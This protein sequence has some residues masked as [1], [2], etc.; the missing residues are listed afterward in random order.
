MRPLSENNIE[1]EL[2]YAYLHAIAAKAGVGCEVA[3]RHD[4][5]T[6][7]D[8]KLTGWGPFPGGGYR[9]EIDIKVQLKATVQIPNE[10]NG[11]LSY[12]L[13][14]VQ[15]YDDLRSDAVSTP[16]ILVVLFLPPVAEEW[17]SL[18]DDGLLLRKC[19]YW[20]SL[21]GAAHT[22]NKSGQT[23]YL[24]KTQIFGQDELVKLM[25]CLSKNIIPLYQC[26][27]EE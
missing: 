21:R 1:S 19:A 24:P 8:A 15:Q 23:I 11:K 18:T 7:V 14:G 9:T 3:G 16:R 13:K 27:G 5:N 20:V 22:T 25:T 2:S 10:I 12:F 4:D 26:E 17:L 6:G